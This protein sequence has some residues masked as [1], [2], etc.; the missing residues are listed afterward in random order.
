MTVRPLA[1]VKAKLAEYSTRRRRLTQPCMGSASHGSLTVTDRQTDIQTDRQTDG[2][3]DRQ[4][5]SQPALHSLIA[6]LRDAQSVTRPGIDSVLQHDALHGKLL[7]HITCSSKYHH[8]H[9]QTDTAVLHAT[10]QY[11]EGE[12]ARIDSSQLA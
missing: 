2:R 11:S 5:G 6:G 4:T 7:W 10:M 9:V 3:T 1:A 8:F 12:H